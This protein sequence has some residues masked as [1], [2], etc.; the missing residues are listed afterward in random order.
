MTKDKA[1]RR[2]LQIGNQKGALWF[3]QVS[4]PCEEMWYFITGN[5]AL[6]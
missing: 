6:K 4:E 2:L 5:S 3:K 1:E